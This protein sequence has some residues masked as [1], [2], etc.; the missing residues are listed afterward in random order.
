MPFRDRIALS[1]E[2]MILTIWLNLH[3]I[4]YRTRTYNLHDIGFIS[5]FAVWIIQ[6]W[7][8]QAFFRS[9]LFPDKNVLPR[10][11]WCPCQVNLAVLFPGRSLDE[12]FLNLGVPGSRS[13]LGL[14]FQRT[15]FWLWTSN[16]FRNPEFKRRTSNKPELEYGPKFDLEL[17][18]SKL[19][20]QFASI[21]SCEGA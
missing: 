13:F 11:E 15:S 12:R 7:P 6:L 17:E 10:S 20:F 18:W 8:D 5:K 2:Y 14:N 16:E 3:A 9:F 21:F 1:S 19:D 4:W